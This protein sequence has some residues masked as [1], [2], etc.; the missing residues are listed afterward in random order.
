MHESQ[1]AAFRNRQR[2][3]QPLYRID[4]H[5]FVNAPEQFIEARALERGD[6]DI[7]VGRGERVA[8]LAIQFDRFY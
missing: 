4:G 8:G 3:A 1:F 7:S 6:I 2:K 5:V